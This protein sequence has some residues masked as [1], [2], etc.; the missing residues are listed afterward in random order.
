MQLGTGDAVSLAAGVS[1]DL[2]RLTLP[3]EMQ[4]AAR[5]DLPSDMQKAF[6]PVLYELTLGPRPAKP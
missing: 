6:V 1:A 3:P 2:L 5:Q 4:E